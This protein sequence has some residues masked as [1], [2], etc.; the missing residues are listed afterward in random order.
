MLFLERFIKFFIFK[1]LMNYRI[2]VVTL[3]A[4][5]LISSSFGSLEVSNFENGYVRINVDVDNETKYNDSLVVYLDDG[6]SEKEICSEDILSE[7][8]SAAY[9][10]KI[11][12][13][14]VIKP[15]KYILKVYLKRDSKIVAYYEVSKDFSITVNKDNTSIKCSYMNKTAYFD[16]LVNGGGMGK[17]VVKIFIPKS[18]MKTYSESVFF[19]SLPYKV[20]KTDPLIAWDVDKLP[21][22][23]EFEVKTDTPPTRE[24]L[25]NMT[26]SVEEKKFFTKYFFIVLTVLLI[27]FI[28][29]QMLLKP[30]NS[31]I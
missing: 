3:F 31:T 22:H 1:L 12:N 9:I 20:L 29:F 14:E 8:S 19:S 30:K 26:V 6:S 5:F 25:E 2:F 4:L 23:V 13:F 21:Q 15:G 10:S 28:V 16:V 24:D 7:D 18:I 17:K 27:V 11:C